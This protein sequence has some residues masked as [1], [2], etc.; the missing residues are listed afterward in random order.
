MMKA[1]LSGKVPSR[2][3]ATV[4]SRQ[5]L[6]QVRPRKNS[7]CLSEISLKWMMKKKGGNATSFL[8][9]LKDIGKIKRSDTPLDFSADPAKIRIEI[10]DTP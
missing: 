7:L 4:R 3:V 9:I 2:S 1:K 6:L 8:E 10:L 5:H